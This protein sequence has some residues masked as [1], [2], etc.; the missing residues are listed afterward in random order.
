MNDTTKPKEPFNAEEEQKSYNKYK[1]S[2]GSVKHK[3][4]NIPVDYKINKQNK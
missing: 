2:E 1:E 3:N 4:E